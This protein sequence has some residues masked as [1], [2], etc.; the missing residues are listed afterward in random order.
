MLVSLQIGR[1]KFHI[2][3]K[4]WTEHCDLEQTPNALPISL[5]PGSRSD[6][7]PLSGCL[8]RKEWR[9]KRLNSSSRN[10]WWIRP[11]HLRCLDQWLSGPARSPGW[12]GGKKSFF[13][14]R[15]GRN[16]REGFP[17][18]T[19]EE[20]ILEATWSVYL[21]PL[22]L[23]L[24]C[25]SEMF[26]SLCIAACWLGDLGKNNFPSLGIH[27][28]ICTMVIMVGPTWTDSR[29]DWRVYFMPSPHHSAWH[30]TN[31]D[32]FVKRSHVCTYAAWS[33]LY[34]KPGNVWP[35]QAKLNSWPNGV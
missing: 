7:C 27:F 33:H 23:F 14:E 17:L 25:L 15:K 32:Y 34:R 18:L 4:R 13:R 28:S 35:A 11:T 29:R 21:T 6:N 16:G 30:M 8:P 9:G 31:L 19:L 24:L 22:T 1:P 5:S 12:A 20:K 3:D 10:F 2:T 26:R